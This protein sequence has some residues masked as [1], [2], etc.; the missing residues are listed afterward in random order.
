MAAWWVDF[1]SGTPGCIEAP[2]EATVIAIARVKLG[3][4]TKEIS[5]IPF[6]AE[7]RLHKNTALNGAAP[8]YCWNP[9]KCAQARGCSDPKGC[10]W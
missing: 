6:P 7:P 2:D 5:R 8:S 4:G 10:A 3:R 9:V 1:E